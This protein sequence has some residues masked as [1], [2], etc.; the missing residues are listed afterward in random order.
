VDQHKE[1]CAIHRT[2]QEMEQKQSEPAD[3]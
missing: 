1:W 3:A 2:R